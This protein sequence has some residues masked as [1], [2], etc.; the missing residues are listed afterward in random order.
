METYFLALAVILGVAVVSP[1]FVSVSIRNVSFVDSLWSLF[2]LIAAIVY[3]LAASDLGLRGLLVLGLVAIWALR[4]SIYITARNWGK[5]EDSRYQ[6][7]RKG[8]EPFWIKS[9]YIVFILQGLLAWIVSLPLL[10][11]ITHP[12][13]IGL[14]DGSCDSA[15]EHRNRL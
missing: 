4:L 6:K 10:V 2:F 14:I 15:L 13:P 7:I 12:A 5:P 1:G 8:N 3:T 9:L 11:A